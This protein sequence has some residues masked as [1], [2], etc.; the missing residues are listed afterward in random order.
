MRFL[1]LLTLEAFAN[2]KVKFKFSWKTRK[3]RSLFVFK[4]PVMHKAN[5][6]YKG[7]CSCSEFYVGETKRNC[8]IRWREHCSTEKTSEVGDHLL[9]NPGH[10]VN[11]KILTNARK[12]A[13]KPEILE[14]FFI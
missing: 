2:Y 9:L 11:W 5:V 12:Q 14:T 8:E 4:D 7:T 3:V 6:I 10:T 1:V 13:Y